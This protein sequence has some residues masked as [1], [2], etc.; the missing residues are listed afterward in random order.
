MGILYS[1]YHI[2]HKPYRPE[3]YFYLFF[4]YKKIEIYKLH[5]TEMYDASNELII[6][7]NKLSVC[8]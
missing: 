7:R 2:G 8:L 6:K 3:S 5:E 4:Q 1:L